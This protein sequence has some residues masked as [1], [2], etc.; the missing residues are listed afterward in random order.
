MTD[1]LLSMTYDSNVEVER[2][3]GR[4]ITLW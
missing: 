1:Q 4:T 2:V 3:R